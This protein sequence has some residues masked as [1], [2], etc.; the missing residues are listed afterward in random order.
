MKNK[1]IIVFVVLLNYSIV[2]KFEINRQE[3]FIPATNNYILSVPKDHNIH[4]KYAYEWWYFVSH[5]FEDKKQESKHATFQVVIFRLSNNMRPLLPP[6]EKKGKSTFII[7]LTYSDLKNK[8]HYHTSYYVSDQLIKSKINTQ[9]FEFNAPGLNFKIQKEGHVSI[10]AKALFPQGE[11]IEIETDLNNQKSVVFHGEQGYSRKGTCDTC[12]SHYLSS[13][14]LLGKTS[15]KFNKSKKE[16]HSLAWHD[17]EFGSQ[18]LDKDQEGWDW[19]SL[20]LNSKEEFMIFRVRNQKNPQ[21]NYYAGTYIDQRGQSKNLSPNK[22]KL[23]PTQF[24]KL[25]DGANYPVEWEISIQD[26]N[27]RHFK[28]TADYDNQLNISHI[29][30]FPNYWEGSC[31]VTDLKTNKIIGHA[32]MELTG[33]ETTKKINF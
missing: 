29:Y 2:A 23:K 8:N 22:I 5:L 30:N 6:S 25:K 24:I 11:M 21:K 19:F 10:Y 17:H 13:T 14:R 18:T 1:I 20:Q 32:Y 27:T 12:A 26:K 9:F 4:S 3:N 7:N 16:F 28:I 33:Y 15:I 31:Y